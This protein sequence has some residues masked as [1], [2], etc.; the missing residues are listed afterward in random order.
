MTLSKVPSKTS[1][2]F[3]DFPC[4]NVP[5]KFNM[6]QNTEKYLYAK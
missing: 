1:Q 4:A 6:Y 5:E 3:S 2:L